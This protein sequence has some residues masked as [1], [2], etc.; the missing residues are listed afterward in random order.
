MKV[1]LRNTRV[2]LAMLFDFGK[3]KG[4]QVDDVWCGKI[5]TDVKQV[6]KQY[7]IEVMNALTLKSTH[8]KIPCPELETVIDPGSLKLFKK[9]RTEISFEVTS[10]YLILDIP[11]NR[12]AKLIGDVVLSLFEGNYRSVVKGNSWIQESDDFLPTYTPNSEQF[13]WLQADPGYVAWCINNVDHFYISPSYLAQISQLECQYLKSIQIKQVKQDIFSYQAV[14][15]T[16]AYN[17]PAQIVQKNT[18]KAHCSALENDFEDLST[19]HQ[20]NSDYVPRCQSCE[21]APCMCSD[22]EKTSSFY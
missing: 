12:Y 9:I 1:K 13:L 2:L 22:P 18:F 10:K 5:S 21:E 6:I 16:L 19:F 17:L 14:F 8:F 4:R 3:Y 15:T 20:N 7:I 11:E